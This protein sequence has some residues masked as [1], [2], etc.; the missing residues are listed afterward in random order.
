MA[1]IKKI[2]DKPGAPGKDKK[3]KNP[4]LNPD[5]G[6]DLIEKFPSYKSKRKRKIKR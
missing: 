3:N 2:K 6:F 4:F 1:K 5:D